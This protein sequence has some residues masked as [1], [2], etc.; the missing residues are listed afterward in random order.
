MATT[1]LAEYIDLAQSYA[2]NESKEHCYRHC[3]VA[4]QRV[5]PNLYLQSDCDEA[6]A[7]R[8]AAR[9]CPPLRSSR[10]FF[11]TLR[12]HSEYPQELLIHVSQKVKV[13]SLQ[14]QGPADK[15][16]MLL[17]RKAPCKL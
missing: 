3:L 1:D 14:I 7:H 15:G 10:D 4:Q 6:S 2:L 5:D 12:C 11:R 17:Y 9:K 13:N 8:C 16:A